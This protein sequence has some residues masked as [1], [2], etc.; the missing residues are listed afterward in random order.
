MTQDRPERGRGPARQVLD[1]LEA[2]LARLGVGLTRLVGGR[3]FSRAAGALGA[4]AGRWAPPLHRRV[5][6]NLA[7]LGRDDDPK[8][9]S[10]E[11]C[12]TFAE[13]VVDYWRLDELAARPDAIAVE[14]AEHL[15]RPLRAGRGVVIAGA[16]FGAWEAVRLAARKLA[17][18]DC[19]LIYRAFNNPRV[20][21]IAQERIRYGGAPVLH[22][23][24]A[25]AR[26][27]LRHVGRGG[28][29]MVL[30]DQRQTGSPLLPFLGREAETATAAADLALR[31]DAALIT[32]RARR[33]PD[34]DRFH[35]V[36]EPE[37]PPGDALA[38]MREVNDRVSAWVA[39]TPGQWFWLHRRWTLRA[40]GERIR[41]ARRGDVDADPATRA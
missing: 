38:M 7:L 27:L 12:R 21:A 17:G 25:G 26:A 35:A 14:G 33:D 36:F 29:A 24:P 3:R 32:A 28:M 37:V 8:A 23:G 6:A 22:K 15:L 39:A 40:R 1:R 5:A 31:F 20:D 11:V 19:A 30:V 16:H 4:V 13:L 34:G 18:R 41:A 9:L 2:G 10:A